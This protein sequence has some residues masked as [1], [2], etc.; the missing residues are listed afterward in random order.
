MGSA[1]TQLDLGLVNI[2]FKCVLYSTGGDFDEIKN[3]WNC[4][5]M[6]LSFSLFSFFLSHLFFSLFLLSFPYFHRVIFVIIVSS[7]SRMSYLQIFSDVYI[8]GQIP[9]IWVQI[10]YLMI[11]TI[12]CSIPSY[13]V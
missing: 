6:F 12:D 3:M 2:L 8:K 1:Q 11:V 13:R 9:K 7:T 5:S 10:Q 4:M